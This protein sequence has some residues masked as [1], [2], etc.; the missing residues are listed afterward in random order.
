[1]IFQKHGFQSNVE[2]DFMKRYELEFRIKLWFYSTKEET[3][4]VLWVKGKDM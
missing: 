1:M 4:Y 2:N 3:L